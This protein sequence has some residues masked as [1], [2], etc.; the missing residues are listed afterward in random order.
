[1]PDKE[2]VIRCPSCDGYGW[3]EDDETAEAVDCDWCKGIGYVYRSADGVDR[4]IPR[5]DAE[6]VAETIENLERERLHALGYSGQA[7]KPWEQD[8][9]KGTKGGV[10]PYEEKP[11]EE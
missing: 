10:N 3:F 7:K 2:R 11:S 1:M 9:R 5:Q 4:P 8:I 6:L